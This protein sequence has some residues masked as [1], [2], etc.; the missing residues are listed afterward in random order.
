MCCVPLDPSHMVFI[1]NWPNA[2]LESLLT[3]E[4]VAAEMGS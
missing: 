4:L 3:A 2:V 1:N